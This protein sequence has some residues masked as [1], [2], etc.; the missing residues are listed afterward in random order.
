MDQTCFLDTSESRS[1]LVNSQ[2]LQI[3]T[4][5]AF[6]ECL[7]TVF[8]FLV[9]CLP[10][11]FLCNEFQ[12]R[13]TTHQQQRKYRF[14]FKATVI[15]QGTWCY[16]ENQAAMKTWFLLDGICKDKKVQAARIL[17][18]PA[19][20]ITRVTRV[21]RMAY[22]PRLWLIAIGWWNKINQRWKLKLNL[23]KFEEAVWVLIQECVDLKFSDTVMTSQERNKFRAQRSKHMQRQLR[24]DRLWI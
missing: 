22:S 2:I 1:C 8:N 10:V 9:F 3:F 5:S 23:T 4:V 19:Y 21:T 20:I 14:W 24:S 17:D 7:G 16:R 12:V 6:L 15:L 13:L 11:T 18:C